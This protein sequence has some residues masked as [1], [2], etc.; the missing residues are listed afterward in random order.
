MVIISIMMMLLMF[1]LLM[2]M[3]IMMMNVI[4]FTS[5]DPCL[6]GACHSKNRHK[7]TH[8]ESQF[9]A[10]YEGDGQAHAYVRDVL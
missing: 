3:M 5:E 4:D 6:H 9:P 10:H 8:Y 2:M 1:L 7:S